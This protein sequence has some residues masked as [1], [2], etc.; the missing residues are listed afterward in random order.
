MSALDGIRR[1]E[2][3]LPPSHAVSSGLQRQWRNSFTQSHVLKHI[4]DKQKLQKHETLIEICYPKITAFQCMILLSCGD[5]LIPT[6]GSFCSL[7]KSHISLF[8]AGV[9]ISQ[10]RKTA[11]KHETFQVNSFDSSTH[12]LG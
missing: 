9:A 10:I 8:L 6:G 3:I 2:K 5:P 12:K 4:K 7:L 11:S 1:V